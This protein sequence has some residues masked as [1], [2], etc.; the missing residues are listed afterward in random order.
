MSDEVITRIILAKV[1]VCVCL[2]V[3]VCV[4]KCKCGRRG[5]KRSPAVQSILLSPFSQIKDI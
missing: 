1:C 2:C 4:H 3:C 5:I